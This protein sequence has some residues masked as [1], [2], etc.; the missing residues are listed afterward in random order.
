M[1]ID[2]PGAVPRHIRVETQIRAVKMKAVEIGRAADPRTT[3][4]DNEVFIQTHH[5]CRQIAHPPI[6]P[7][8]IGNAH[9]QRARSRSAC[10][11]SQR[12]I[13]IAAIK[14]VKAALQRRRAIAD[15]QHILMA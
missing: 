10:I 9:H 15:Q 2:H 5:A 4:H 12:P 8:R 7:V 11:S 1:K 3:L 14:I 6:N 13:G